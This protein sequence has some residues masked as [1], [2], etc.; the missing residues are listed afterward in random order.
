MA[1]RALILRPG[2]FPLFDKGK[3][4][5]NGYIYIGKPDLDPEIVANQKAITFLQEDGTE[6]PGT[7]PVRT[8]AGGVPTYNGSPVTVLANGST[9]INGS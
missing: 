4:V 9:P 3:P 2:Y 7:Q 8:S 1:T 6:V 5:A